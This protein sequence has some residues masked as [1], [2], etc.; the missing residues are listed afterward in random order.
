MLGLQQKSKSWTESE[1][2][3]FLI[4][5]NSNP[6]RSTS[7]YNFTCASLLHYIFKFLWVTF[8]AKTSKDL[9]LILITIVLSFTNSLSRTS[10]C[11]S[12]KTSFVYSNLFSL[13]KTVTIRCYIQ[14]SKCV[15]SPVRSCTLRAR[16]RAQLLKIITHQLF[17]CCRLRQCY[18]VPFRLVIYRSF[19]SDFDGFSYLFKHSVTMVNPSHIHHIVWDYP[20]MAIIRMSS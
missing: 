7:D 17:H 20:V 10:L 19:S 15:R 6:Y 12:L 11:F 13:A 9:E 4:S 3:L 14:T 18:R 2:G 5:L 16:R 8:L 1:L